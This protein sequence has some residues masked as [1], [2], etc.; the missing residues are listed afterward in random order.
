MV[1]KLIS[2][3]KLLRKEKRKR[4]KQVKTETEMIGMTD[5]NEDIVNI[6]LGVENWTEDQNDT[7]LDP[8]IVKIGTGTAKAVVHTNRGNFSFPRLVSG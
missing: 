7:V 5:T 1:F 2:V 6:T 4:R 3:R 8:K